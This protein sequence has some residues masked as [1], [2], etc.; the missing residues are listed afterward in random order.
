MVPARP[1]CS[2]SASRKGTNLD[3]GRAQGSQG[4]QRCQRT[5]P[6]FGTLAFSTR[7]PAGA[8]IWPVPDILF[9]IMGPGSM[10][11]SALWAGITEEEQVCSDS[12]DLSDAATME[13]QISVSSMVP[14]LYFQRTWTLPRQGEDGGWVSATIPRRE[15]GDKFRDLRSRS[16]EADMERRCHESL[17]IYVFHHCP[18]QELATNEEAHVFNVSSSSNHLTRGCQA[19]SRLE[20]VVEGF[21]ERLSLTTQRM[22]SGLQKN[23]KAKNSWSKH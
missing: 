5:Q 19:M 21:T 20:I 22:K 17:V 1:S 23:C 9:G 18:G 10:P 12:T 16:G 3:K 7:W 4:W 6:V 11:G 14:V 2:P 15:W 8:A 13:P